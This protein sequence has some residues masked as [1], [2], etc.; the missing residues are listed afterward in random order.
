MS[1]PLKHVRVFRF[2]RSHLFLGG[3]RELVLITALF[4]LILIVILQDWTAAIVGIALWCMALPLYR[5][6]ANA[7][8]N[9]TKVY[10][11]YA[12]YQPFYAAHGMKHHGKLK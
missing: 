9:M 10:R 8:P 12:S 6:M 3:E 7:D 5:L 11:T 4:C 2:N 1:E